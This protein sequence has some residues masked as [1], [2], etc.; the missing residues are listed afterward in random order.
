MTKAW[1]AAR[2]IGLLGGWRSQRGEA[3]SAVLTLAAVVAGVLALL[4]TTAAVVDRTRINECIAGIDAATARLKQRF[5][6]TGTTPL[7]DPDVIYIK[8]CKAYADELTATISFPGN[9]G[10]LKNLKAAADAALQGVGR[11]A[12]LEV[13]PNPA[14]SGLTHFLGVTANIPLGGGSA[15]VSASASV[16]GKVLSTGLVSDGGFSWSGTFGVSDESSDHAAGTVSEIVVTAQANLGA[17]V[18]GQCPAGSTLGPGGQCVVSCTTAPQNVVWEAPQ[19][20]QI[21]LF[22]ALPDAVARGSLSLVTLAWNVRHAESVSIDQGIGEVDPKSGYFLEFPPDQDT[23]YT[24][25]ARGVRA[26]DTQTASAK[27]TV[28]LPPALT[29]SSPGSNST[30][31][32]DSVAVTGTVLRAPPGAVVRLSVNGVAKVD[33]PVA[34]G[35][36]AAS[37]A[38]DKR[39]G[40]FDLSLSNPNFAINSC[41]PR[42]QP[43]VLRAGKSLADVTNVITATLVG[44]QPEVSASA[45]VFHAAQVTAFRVVWN[46]CPP[47]NKD[48][49]RSVTLSAGQSIQVGTVDCGTTNPGGFVQTCSVTASV[50]TTV[51]GIDDDATWQ[52]NIFSCP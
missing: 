43:V 44:S 37:V 30:V 13:L 23:V 11:C 12:I 2:A 42:T 31:T 26:E 8:A 48:E 17:A 7:D 50:D 45:T 52:F 15:V 3:V 4:P 10:A 16:L 39:L 20:P 41:G 33:V 21:A 47:L 40:L 46:S 27:I 28:Q 25:T 29:L 6:A 19:I 34:G 18:N 14:I 22:K 24:L 9:S 38:L 32:S 5:G 1:R 36:F 51:G 35:G 49:A